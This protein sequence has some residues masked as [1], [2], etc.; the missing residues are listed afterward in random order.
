MQIHT[1]LGDR[2][3]ALHVYQS[4]A[5]ILH[6]ELGVEPAPATKQLH[7]QLRQQARIAEE[8]RVTP[9]ALQRP[10]MAGRHAEWQRLLETWRAIQEGPARC[11]II[12]GEAGIG[13]TRLAEE[14]IDWVRHH[15]HAWASSRSYAAQGT[16]VYAPVT[17]WLRAPAIQ[18]A[19]EAIDDLW[20][21]E[22]ARLLPEVLSHRPDLPLPVPLQETWQQQRFFESILHALQ[23]VPGPLLLHLDDMQWSGQE[24]LHFVHFLLHNR[25]KSPLLLVGAIR[26]EDAACCVRSPRPATRPS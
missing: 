15:G 20:R 8:P 11:V 3:S 21:V 16:L 2:A 10:R 26:S 4:C 25:R 6:R 13:K 5:S 17:E 9:Y 14:L 1:L 24:T 7:D 19:L 23:A 22:I 12:W 18:P